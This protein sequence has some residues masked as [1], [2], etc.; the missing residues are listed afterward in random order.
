MVTHDLAAGPGWAA[1][2]ATAASTL[3][4]A[5]LVFGE[6][7]TLLLGE[8]SE[9]LHLREGCTHWPAQLMLLCTIVC[10]EGAAWHR[11][12]RTALAVHLHRP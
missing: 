5:A 9:G 6:A 2:A 8:R 7:G 3:A 12:G 1:Q 11:R 4:A 10:C